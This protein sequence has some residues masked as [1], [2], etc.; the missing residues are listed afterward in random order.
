SAAIAPFVGNF[1]ADLLGIKGALLATAAV[2][3]AGAFA[4]ACYS[5]L[6]TPNRKVAADKS[7]RRRLPQFWN[8]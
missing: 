4:F 6:V 3:A 7:T 1:A 8:K 2:R 5:G